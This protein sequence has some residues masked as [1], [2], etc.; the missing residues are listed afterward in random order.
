[1]VVTGAFFLLGC[2]LNM[3][4]YKMHDWS[5]HIIKV[6]DSVSQVKTV[7]AQFIATAEMNVGSSRRT[8]TKGKIRTYDGQ[9]T[10]KR[11]SRCRP[12]VLGGH[13]PST[14]HIDVATW[15]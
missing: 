15:R 11:Q 1:M 3:R 4:R 7:K 13:S 10:S 5:C 12:A 2:V 9:F 8:H 6:S 14:R